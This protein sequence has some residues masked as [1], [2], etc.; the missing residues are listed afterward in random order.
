VL[1]LMDNKIEAAQCV[2]NYLTIA[3]REYAAAHGFTGRRPTVSASLDR[4]EEGQ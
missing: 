4:E 1:D 2:P 3:R